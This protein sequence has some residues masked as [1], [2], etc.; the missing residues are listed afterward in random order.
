MTSQD[1]LLTLDEC[2]KSLDVTE[3]QLAQLLHDGS[4]FLVDVDHVPRLPALFVDS[5]LN[6]NRLLK[7]CRFI[8]PAPP[9]SRLDFLISPQGGHSS[10][11]PLEM[12]EDS[13]DFRE[14][15]KEAMAWAAGWS[16]T[17]VSVYQGVNAARPDAVEPIY[18]ASTEI[19]P[20]RRL[21]KRSL[22]A[23]LLH[24]YELP[25]SPG[26]DVDRFTLFV[27][28]QTI[29]DTTRKVEACVQVSVDNG[30]ATVEVKAASDGVMCSK[31][32]SCGEV[33]GLLDIAKHV[34]SGLMRMR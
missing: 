30:T 11:S 23:L 31:T 15:L 4:F 21:W 7:L 20:R 32:F 24:E 22:Q 14:L 9:A 13:Q 18:A 27:E 5:T 34:V 2:R 29:G 33:D 26:S 1:E 17:T 8:V 16:R 25:M 19:D 3:E 12:L 10:R 28:Q 6:R